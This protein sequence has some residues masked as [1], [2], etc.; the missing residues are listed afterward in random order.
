MTRFKRFKDF[1]Y[2][3]LLTPLMVVLLPIA[4]DCFISI[5]VLG[6]TDTSGRSL[7]VV[8]IA[9]DVVA[10]VA[11]GIFIDTLLTERYRRKHGLPRHTES[12]FPG[13]HQ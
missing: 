11:V 4:V 5:N 10:F 8:A 3:A 1:I 7:W 12:E 9:L 13:F 6:F 2:L